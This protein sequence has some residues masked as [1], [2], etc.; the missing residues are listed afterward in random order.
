MTQSRVLADTPVTT[1]GTNTTNITAND[2]QIARGNNHGKNLIING[3]M[4]INQREFTTLSGTFNQYTVDRMFA[5]DSGATATVTLNTMSLADL[6]TIGYSDSTNYLTMDVT[7]GDNYAG[8]EQRI[9]GLKQFSGRQVTLSFWAKGTNP[10]TAGNLRITSI[11]NF[12]TSGS[13]SSTV[14]TDVGTFTLTSS[15]VKQSITFVVNDS[16]TKTFGTDDNAYLRLSIGQGSDTSTDAWDLDIKNVQLEFGDTATEFEYVKPSE[17]LANCKRYFERIPVTQFESILTLQVLSTT[18]ARGGS[19]GFP[20]KRTVPTV[21]FSNVTNWE[22]LNASGS[23]TPNLLTLTPVV[24]T[25]SLS[26]SV[27]VASGV[28]SGNAT[29]LRP[30][31]TGEYID[32]DAEL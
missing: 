6:Q 2:V 3:D 1:I 26:V 9:E 18:D 17:Q 16:T 28:V 4:A 31:T 11:E 21:L 32:I 5:Q 15:W 14:L 24:S 29:T 30:S 13:P 8:I 10:T 25:S 22:I 12:G 23:A 27:T 20:A 7:A 19:I